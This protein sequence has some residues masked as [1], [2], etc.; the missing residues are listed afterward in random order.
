MKKTP[1]AGGGRRKQANNNTNK[2]Q[3]QHKKGLGFT[4]DSPLLPKKSAT[5]HF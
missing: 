3:R 1:E 4:R 5:G 2:Q